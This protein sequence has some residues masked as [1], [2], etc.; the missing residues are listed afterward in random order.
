MRVHG[1]VFVVQGLLHSQ[2]GSDLPVVWW[3]Y[4]CVI[5]LLCWVPFVMQK[6]TVQNVWMV[7]PSWVI[8]VNVWWDSVEHTVKWKVCWFTP[9]HHV[10]FLFICILL[11]ILS[12]CSRYWTICPVYQFLQQWLLWLH[13][14]HMHLPSFLHWRVLQQNSQWVLVISRSQVPF[15]CTRH[16]ACVLQCDISWCGMHIAVTPCGDYYCFNGGECVEED[17]NSICKCEDPFYGE[18]CLYYPEREG[19][20]S[21]ACWIENNHSVAMLIFLCPTACFCMNGGYGCD[22]E[23]KNG[24][25]TCPD[26]FTGKHCEYEICEYRASP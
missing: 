20:L 9:F 7:G 10:K 15:M 2:T 3:L 11:S 4:A 24:T 8:A 16:T 22:N 26:N 17:G 1:T 13:L 12:I 6:L 18:Y 5:I 23:T 19:I 21:L 25:C 14:R